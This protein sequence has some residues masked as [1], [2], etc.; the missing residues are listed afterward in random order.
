MLTRMWRAA[1]LCVIAAAFA[2]AQR[3]FPGAPE[4]TQALGRLNTVGS[5]LVI[6]AH[7]DDERAALLAW[8][9]RER[10]L[11][12]A[13]LSLTRGEGGQNLIGPEQGELLGV[14]RTQELLES[15][16]YDG[17]EQFFSSA[18][19]FGFSKTAEEAL[20]IWDREKV[21]G[22]I[23]RI[24]REFRPDVILLQFSG[25]PRDGHG[26]HQ[27]SA[28]L[29]KEAFSAAAD[30]KRFSEQLKDVATWQ[31]KR[32]I[33]VP[34]GNVEANFT[35]DAGVYNP[36][37]GY[38][39]GEIAGLGRSMHRSQGEGSP[40]V[41]GPVPLKFVHVAGDR[42]V[43]DP[44]DGIDVTWARVPGGRAAGDLL[45]RAEQQLDPKHPNDIVPLLVDARRAIARISS[46]AGREQKLHECDEAI[47]LA[48]GLWLDAA[49][50]TAG[51]TPGSTV[52]IRATA[53]ART[54]AS[55]RLRS[56]QIGDVTRQG[57]LLALGQ[58][59]VHEFE[60][61]VPAGEPYTQTWSPAA[62]TGEARP[63]V[64]A[65]F[66]LE[67]GNETLTITRPVIFRYVDNV[68]GEV[69]RPFVVVPAVSVRFAE[70]SAL[71][72]SAAARRVT[73]EVRANVAGAQGRVN[74]SV[75]AGWS[76][77]PAAAPFSLNRPGEQAV[78]FFDVRP[79]ERE[80]VGEAKSTATSGSAAV[81]LESHTIEYPHIKAQT[82][83]LPAVTKLVRADVKTLSRNIGYVMGAGDEVPRALEQI[84]C[85]VTQLTADDLVHGDLT[86]FEAIVTG[87]RAYNT[88]ED[89]VA[90][91]QRLLRYVEAGGTLV[92]Q[93][94]KQENLPANLGPYP[95]TVRNDRV[96]VENGPVEIMEGASPLLDK[97]NKITDADFEGWVQERGLYFARSWDP[98]YHALIQASDPGEKPLA[99][100]I[101]YTRYGKG[102]YV[103]AAYSWFRELPAGVP[104]AYRLFA[105]L[106]SAGKTLSQ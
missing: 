13:Y 38:S 21:L 32:L 26:Q 15:R 68:L 66:T 97:P 77:D 12:T 47:A 95:I 6:A 25:T 80:C 37:L 103:F 71:F 58:P 76:V 40:Q 55:V 45:T 73:A 39:Y 78:L 2:R 17:A 61:H 63:V 10:K 44:L 94:N 43:K 96:T 3:P 106:L 11:R 42:A 35:V 36:V 41:R 18:V 62:G 104:G 88:R 1:F 29:G 74:V 99:G 101:L 7:P 30:P 83:L 59:A 5:V 4:I 82:V 72:P 9:A 69:T 86:R 16:K 64:S 52:K 14:I 23:V 49:G 20:R 50:S 67:V 89:L 70:H 46:F 31:A 8:L 51:A 90:N 53:L 79:P 91:Q 92:V 19:D 27:A 57:E 87:I 85:T 93:Y 56:V 84:G 81:D 75:P 60:W 102:A 65:T 24:V 100:G 48:A 22:E 98:H 34:W 33:W 28:I 105:N 54:G